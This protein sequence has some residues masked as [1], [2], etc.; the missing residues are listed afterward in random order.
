MLRHRKRERGNELIEFALVVAFLVPLFLWMFIAGMN[1]IRMIQITQICRDLGSLYIHGI[2]FSTYAAQQVAL[3]L[4]Q[5]YGLQIGSSFVGNSATNDGNAGNGFIVL[6]QV[7]FVGSGACASLPLGTTCTNQNKY[8][9]IER[10]DF[11]N[12]ALQ[13][14]GTTVRSSLGTP[15]ATI[16]PTGSVQNYLTDSGAVAANFASLLQTQLADQQ[17]IYVSETFFAS[18]DL[19]ISAYP[20]GG[21]YSRTFF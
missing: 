20:G 13:F 2:D 11:G 21:L 6:S 10:I 9:F 4:S 14:S 1:L 18:S 3:R 8:V 15:T 5:G 17:V 16:S 7:M 12:K 19:G